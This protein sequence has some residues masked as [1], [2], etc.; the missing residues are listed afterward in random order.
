MIGDQGAG[1]DVDA[2]RAGRG[3]GLLSMA[4]RIKLVE[5]DLSIESQPR[6]G[7]TVRPR[8]RLP[9]AETR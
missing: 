1:F 4:E 7:T 6:M 3:I 5:G 8:V 9:G 2:A